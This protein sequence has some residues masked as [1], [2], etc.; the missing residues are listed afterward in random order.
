[1]L[2]VEL[3]VVKVIGDIK[4]TIK[5]NLGLPDKAVKL[6]KVDAVAAL[7][8]PLKFVLQIVADIRFS[9]RLVHRALIGAVALA[10]AH[11]AVNAT[12]HKR[13][14]SVK[15]PGI[16]RTAAASA[17]SAIT[18]SAAIALVVFAAI[19]VTR[20]RTRT[21]TTAMRVAIISRISRMLHLVVK[22]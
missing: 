14:D 21:R 17:R 10:K 1:M 7:V 2:W 20:A 16:P 9:S 12:W 13:S 11:S 18:A 19:R 8:E 3:A 5:G 15:I 4:A 22:V 6:I